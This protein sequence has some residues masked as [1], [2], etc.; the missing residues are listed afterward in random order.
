MAIVFNLKM[1]PARSATATRPAAP[2]ENP[3]IS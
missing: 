2:E 1:N 3:W